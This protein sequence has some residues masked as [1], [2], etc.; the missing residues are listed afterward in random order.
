MQ[1]EDLQSLIVQGGLLT[2]DELAREVKLLGASGTNQG[3]TKWLVERRRL[4]DFQARA[5]EA[6][7]PGPYMLGPYRVTSHQTAGRLGDVFLAEHVEF[8]QPVSLKVFPA[9]LTRDPERRARLGREARVALQLED[10]IYVVKTLQVGRV[11][12]ISFIAYEELQGETLQQRLNRDERI[13]FDTAC[14]LIQQ[15]A[16]GLA[17]LHSQNIV[18]R[19]ICPANLWLDRDGYL[20]IMEF[21]A[22]H[23]GM[24]FIDSVDEDHSHSN[25]SHEGLL[26]YYDYLP[27][28]QVL[29]P[30]HDSPSNDIYSL[31]CTFYE[32]LTGQ[33]PFPDRNPVRQ[34]L[35]HALEAPRQLSE[36]ELNIPSS[37]QDA[38][39]KMLAKNPADR[40]ESAWKVADALAL[41]MPLPAPP[42]ARPIAPDFL[43]WIQTIDSA[44]ELAT[45]EPQSE[46]LHWLSGL[47]SIAPTSN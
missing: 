47:E 22:A 16:I 8:R 3:L 13:P 15:V 5:V 42:T 39:S 31:G 21:S 34:M 4:T 37:V 25:Y 7:I 10:N 30:N 19:D 11:G 24:S 12:D 29:E 44:E 28:D 35:R 1:V 23:D 18:H 9:E 27:V 14:Q 32:C 17:Y 2:A 40:F 43:N 26:P 20:K 45:P 41:I 36:F 46:F 33:V 6:G 38:V